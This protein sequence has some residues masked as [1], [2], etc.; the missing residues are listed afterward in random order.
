[1]QVLPSFIY[2]IVDF[3]YTKHRM[4]TKNTEKYFILGL[5]L[6]TFIFSFFIFQP[7]WIVL[8]LGASFAIVLSPIHKWLQKIKIPNGIAA[9][10]TVLMF[11]LVL[12]VPVFSIS[13]TIFNESQNVY[14]GVV[15]NG[16]IGTFLNSVESRVN[17]VLPSG[18]AFSIQEVTSTFISYITSNIASIFN[19][20]LSALMSLV[21]LFLSIFYFLKDGKNWKKEIMQLSPISDEN[22]K[23]IID[24][25][26]RTVNGVIVG[27]IM[28][29]LIQGA[30]MWIGLSIFNVPNAAFWGLV[31]AIAALI[32]PF[33]TGVVTVPAV[34][35]L[36]L[37][38]HTLPA[39]GL[40]AW[41]AVIVGTMDNFLDPYI[42]G[43]KTELPPFLILFSV[44]GGIALL[45]PVGILIGPI[46]ISTLHTLILIYKNGPE[47]NKTL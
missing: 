46:T 33:G 34:I 5:L 26:T 29:G 40:L 13:S 15:A 30:L 12:I 38:G 35:Y 44:L 43:K 22:D 11:M 39:L 19:T 32:P 10:I 16:N 18:V 14:Y 31:A 27:Y 6:L 21:L 24:K 41:G 8:V 47:Q 23:K 9:F 1:M 25:L 42:V 7:F 36:F 3:C 28:I 45:G 17:E 20:S 37:S 2:C 4:Q